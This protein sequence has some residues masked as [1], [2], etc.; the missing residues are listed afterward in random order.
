MNVTPDS[1]SDGGSYL[2]SDNAINHGKC[3]IKDGADILDVG[4]ESTR[5]NAEI[6][7]IEEEIDRISPVIDGLARAGAP[8]ISVDT[9]NAR[10]MQAA[11]TLGANVINDVSGLTHDNDAVDIVAQSN[12]PVCIM[13]MQG[14][15]QTMQS[16]P[17]YENV[18]D[19]ILYFF[20][21]RLEFCTA[22]GVD[23]KNIIFDPGIGFGKTV[24]HNLSIIKNFNK[25]KILGCPLLLGGSRKSF[26]GTVCDETEADKRVYGSISAA[27]YGVENGADILRV[28]DVKETRQA[29]K[30]HKA[31]LSAH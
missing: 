16:S 3:L 15:P 21:E 1:F 28:H 7:T 23:Q 17:V 9:R 24:D 29:L 26:I 27:L 2:A 30:V 11:I 19:E 20:E 12:F 22:N 31:I 25:F 13:H 8:Y 4:G 14:N 18:I 6:V 10:T 5:P